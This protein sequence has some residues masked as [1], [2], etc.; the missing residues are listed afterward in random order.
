[1]TNY[2]PSRTSREMFGGRLLLFTSSRYPSGRY[3]RRVSQSPCG[4]IRP[5]RRLALLFFILLAIL[6]F[7]AQ[8]QAVR[9]DYFAS[10]TNASCAP[11][12]QC[13]LLALPGTQVHLCTGTAATLSA[14][15]ASLATTYTNSGAG[16]T[17]PTTAQL[18]PA[19]GGACVSTAD[20][21]GSY[22]FWTI[23]GLY[24]YYLTVPTTAGGGTYGPYP[25]NIGASSGTPA[26]ATVDVNY[27]TLPLACTAAGSGTLYVTRV[28]AGLSTHTYSCGMQ[29]LSSGQV[30][31]ASGQTITMTVQSAPLSTICDMSL[32]GACKITSATGFLYPEWFNSATPI[33]S[34]AN[35]SGYPSSANGT[36]VIPKGYAGT[37]VYTAA[38]VGNVIDCR[39]AGC[40]PFQFITPSRPVTNFPLGGDLDLNADGASD[41]VL[42]H[43][44][45]DNSANQTTTTT[46]S[47]GTQNITV[48]DASK[49][50]LTGPSLGPGVNV[51]PYTATRE[52]CQINSITLP[53]TLNI[54]CAQSHSGTTDIVQIGGTV[55]G[56]QQDI[57]LYSDCPAHVP[58]GVS[59]P[60]PILDQYQISGWIPA[61]SAD[62]FPYG[63]WQF[64]GEL[65]CGAS[66][67]PFPAYSGADCNWRN[68]T[69]ST[70][71]T[72]KSSTDTTLM[73]CPDAGCLYSFSPQP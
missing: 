24:S 21:Q 40:Q 18:T 31:P 52:L 39:L 27:A 22:G 46:I 19:T 37:D 67:G 30:Q 47:P 51:G 55:I 48:Q 3:S 17:C 34:A 29:F 68:A 15:L 16:T 49:F 13:P 12:A 10:T 50:A 70:A 60:T 8:A 45:L 5:M 28:W 14:C 73:R 64:S 72:L 36:V 41:L 1:M 65:T 23:P 9:Y 66:G 61:N 43:D 32:G 26:G 38:T 54:T 53:T 58:A 56:G 2:R 69:N 7:K 57:F 35:A 33:Q 20:T 4:R 11:G 62:T 59:C 6:H 63:A 71:F 44:A 42:A 25:L